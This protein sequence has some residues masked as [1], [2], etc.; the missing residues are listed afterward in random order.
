MA[1]F[2][3]CFLLNQRRHCRNIPSMKGTVRNLLCLLILAWSGAAHAQFTYTTNADGITI[4]V[5]G[6]QGNPWSGPVGI[7]A[8]INGLTVVNISAGAFTTVVIYLH[9]GVDVGPNPFVT[10]VTIPDTVTNIGEGSFMNCDDLTNV[11][12]GAGVISI[13]EGAFV[14]ST[15]MTGFAVDT[16]NSWFTSVDGVLFNKDQTTLIAYP[17]ARS[18]SYTVPG[19]V[20]NIAE[21]AFAYSQGLSGV[22]VPANVARIGQDAFV[23]CPVLPA[24][25]V[26]TNNAFY[27]SVDGVLF[28]KDQSVLIAYPGGRSGSYAVPRTVTNIAEQAF[29][30]CEGLLG[31]VVPGS[32]S[33]IA[34]GTFAGCLSLTNATFSLGLTMIGQSAFQ[35]CTNLVSLILPG[36]VTNI[37]FGAFADCY[38]L[39]SVAVPASLTSIGATA[40]Q[41]CWRLSSVFF[42]GNAPTADA[43]V[44]V[45]DPVTAYY[46]PG[47]AGWADFSTNTGIPAVLWKPLIQANGANF[48]VQSNQFGF[49]ITGTTNIPIV[50]EACTNL[51]QP[52]WVP[53]QS[54]ALTNGLFHFSEPLKSDTP[55]RFYRIGAP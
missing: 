39:K 9:N 55:A 26:D 16:N 29:G 23:Y 7:P 17:G 25:A 8:S 52:V 42:A 3:A 11:V 24:I 15:Q 40:F 6:Y 47:T 49:D 44:F 4:T 2:F 33:C 43:S 27:S 14:N 10:S 50:I 28:N 54:M 51:A 45:V 20:T 53:L 48:G 32:V 1:P 35:R 5:T 37:G 34:S 36:S 18:G 46:L 38:S 41:S 22:A 19:T 13:G 31:I 21:E 12:I 30:A